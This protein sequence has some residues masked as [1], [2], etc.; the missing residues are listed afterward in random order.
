MARSTQIDWYS[1]H[2]FRSRRQRSQH[3]GIRRRLERALRFEPL[4]DRRMLFVTYGPGGAWTTTDLSYS[5]SNLLDGSWAS[6]LTNQQVQEAAQEAMGAW[7][8]VTPLT[9][10]ELADF[11]PMPTAADDLYSATSSPQIRWGHHLIDGPPNPPNPNTLAHAYQ[12]GTDGRNGD[13]HFDNGDT[14]AVNRFLETATHEI[15]HALGLDHPNGDVGDYDGDP[16]TNECP[17][18][19]PAVMHA[20]IVNGDAWDYIGLGSA[21]LLQDDT[22]GMQSLYGTGLGYV[23]NLNNEMHVYGTSSADNMFVSYDSAVDSITV[24][25]GTNAFQ[26]PGQGA[27][28]S[29]IHIHSSLGADT[30]TLGALPAGMSYEIDGGPET[31]IGVPD[32]DILKLLGSTSADTFTLDSTTTGSLSGTPITFSRFGSIEM[33]GLANGDLFNIAELAAGVK[34]TINGGNHDD[35][36]NV[37]NGA[38]GTVVR[39]EIIINGDVGD[40]TVNLAP[41]APTTILAITGAI[42]FNGGDGDDTLNIGSGFA[43]AV[44]GNIT[45]D[46]GETG[47][48]A[49]NKLVF[50]DTNPTYQVAYDIGSDFVTRN[51]LLTQS[52]N[53]QNTQVINIQGGGGKDVVNVKSSATTTIQAFG[54]GG[55]DEFNIGNGTV[56]YQPANIYNGGG[57]VDSIKFDDSQSTFNSTIIAQPNQVSFFGGV[58]WASTST[59]ETV[60]CYAGIGDNT[61]RIEGAIAQNLYVATGAGTDEIIATNFAN[62]FPSGLGFT[63]YAA[64]FDLGTGLNYLTV[65][66]TAGV[67]TSFDLYPTRL[68]YADFP[69][70]EKTDFN[71]YNVTGGLTIKASDD[72]NG[73]RVYGTPPVSAGYQ[74]TLFLN[75]GADQVTLFPHDA[76]GSITIQGSL[77]I[78]GGTD[79]DLVQIQDDASTLPISYSFT[80]PFGPGTTSIG[81]M[82]AASVGA[83]SDVENILINASS[84]SDTFDI[85]TFQSGSSLSIQANV[86]QDV[87]HI[88][89]TGGDVSAGL[90]NLGAFNFDGGEGFDYFRLTNVNNPD[91]WNYT[92]AADYFQTTRQGGPAYLQTFSQ[93]SVEYI[94]MTAG[95]AADNFF[96]LSTPPDTYNTFRGG[97][98]NDVYT[99]G[100]EMQTNGIVSNVAVVND[101]GVGAGVD[102]VVI[103]DRA[104]TTGKRVHVDQYFVSGVP[105]DTL[106]GPG[107]Y[108]YHVNIAGT[109]TLRL[110]SGADQVFEATTFREAVMEEFVLE[111]NDPTSAPGDSLLVTMSSVT[112]PV[113]TPAGAGAGTYSFDDAAPITYNG[114]ETASAMFA[115]DF[116]GSGTVDDADY[117]VFQGNFGNAVPPGTMGDATGDGMVDTA[118]YVVWRKNF[119]VTPPGSGAALAE[120]NVEPTRDAMSARDVLPDA[121]EASGTPLSTLLSAP[122][123]VMGPTINHLH[124][125]RHWR[126]REPRFVAGNRDHGLLAWLASRDS[127]VPTSHD[128][129]GAIAKTDDAARALA[130]AQIAAIDTAFD[131][132]LDTMLTDAI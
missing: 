41:N 108:L 4:E 43:D 82:G 50:H 28:V 64:D 92:R 62:Q 32:F 97:G 24:A 84:G 119:G 99:L 130:A 6:G 120:V 51:G 47:G 42:T 121:P 81:G 19:F 104:S 128:G 2:R 34:L 76:T 49:N 110:G 125:P 122:L 53:Y 13:I 17:P 8:A 126:A 63:T 40:D 38:G 52:V 60:N 23:L 98:G 29:S 69:A 9:F 74:H 116:D 105:G 87:V 77:G 90:T 46:G 132:A 54:Y 36:I 5:Y 72:P 73:V 12:P 25:S 56:E 16:T 111:G 7:S 94:D 95:P 101:V 118:D 131:R 48:S 71:I 86:G 88:T 14:F 107:G 27:N 83:A 78:G 117:Q 115:G 70:F 80:N 57:G 67:L 15:G 21:Y 106:F 66:E 31:A 59:F 113:F 85:H 18:P 123:D 102:S 22:D 30:I 129:L 20:C 45:F 3:R 11:G 39:G 65:D 33:A 79:I 109:L 96:I 26:F 68:A 1:F 103:D 44:T 35:V 124:S 91:A 61:V 127:R 55:N 75:G 112:N 93:Q 10:T 100:N 114:F 89:P 37:A 58:F